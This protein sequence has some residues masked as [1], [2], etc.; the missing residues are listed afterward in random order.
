MFAG[1]GIKGPGNA[2]VGARADEEG[3]LGALFCV[4]VPATLLLLL[5]R[6]CSSQEGGGST[7][8]FIILQPQQLKE[9]LMARGGEGEGLLSGNVIGDAGVDLVESTQGL[10]TRLGSD[11]GCPMSHSSLAF[12]FM[13][14]Q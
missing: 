6:G 8:L 3:L 4:R 2:F 13:R 9:E 12:S 11:T 1:P 7:R 14:T 5:L 10:R